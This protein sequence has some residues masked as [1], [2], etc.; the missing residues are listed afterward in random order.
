MT[1][2]E[3][4]ARVVEKV[5]RLEKENTR[6][7]KLAQ[8]VAKDANEDA[9]TGLSNR[10]HFEVELKT[11]IGNLKKHGTEFAVLYIDLDRFKFVILR[12]LTIGADHFSGGGSIWTDL[13]LVHRCFQSLKL[14][15]LRSGYNY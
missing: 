2:R 1:D 6:L 10:R 5:H 4:Y 14:P 11:W 8:S 9:L 3:S 13:Q 7:H 12:F 15:N